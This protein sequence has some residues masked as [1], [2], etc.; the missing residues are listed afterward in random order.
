MPNR[1]EVEAQARLWCGT[2]YHH[3][4]RRRGASCDCIGLVIGVA[5]ELRLPCPRDAELPEYGQWPSNHIAQRVADKLMVPAGDG[6]EAV[7]P[8]RVGMFWWR[9][10]G[11]GQHF[12]VFGT[13]RGRLTMIHAFYTLGRV[14]EQGVSEFWRKRLVHVY[15]FSGVT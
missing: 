6:W 9:E 4:G 11:H 2:K 12:A 10:R 13:H 7:A 14:T 15:D 8:G 3:Q 5:R 1:A